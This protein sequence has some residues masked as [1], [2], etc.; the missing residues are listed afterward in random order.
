[1]A[2]YQKDADVYNIGKGLFLNDTYLWHILI[3]DKYNTLFFI[4]I[5]GIVRVPRISLTEVFQL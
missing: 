3:N 2:T 5:M 1:M 4:Y